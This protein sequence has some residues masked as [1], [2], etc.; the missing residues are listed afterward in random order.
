M[1]SF[2][3]S[4]PWLANRSSTNPGKGAFFATDLHAIL[5]N[6]GHPATHRHGSNDG[7]LRQYDG[8]R[9]KRPW[10]RLPRSRGLR[11]VLTSRNFRI[12]DLR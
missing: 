1:T 6:R 5:Q 2:R 9:S 11:A 3:N 8:A 12:W 4:I 7:G 10:L